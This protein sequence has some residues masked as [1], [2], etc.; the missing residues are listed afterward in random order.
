[1]RKFVS[2]FGV[3]FVATA[4]GVSP[5][6]SDTRSLTNPDYKGTKYYFGMNQLPGYASGDPTTNAGP[7]LPPAWNPA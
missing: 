4:C 3:A 6:G 5:S 1:M 2:L 7:R